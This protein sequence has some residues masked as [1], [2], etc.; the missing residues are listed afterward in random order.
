MPVQYAG[1]WAVIMI[2]YA[3]PLAVIMAYPEF[4]GKIFLP[5][6]IDLNYLGEK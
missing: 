4:T 2:Q 3:C 6:K 5:I 1:P